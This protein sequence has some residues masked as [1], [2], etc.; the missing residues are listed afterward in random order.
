MH[1]LAGNPPAEPSLRGEV[2]VI[3]V[4]AQFTLYV[5]KPPG[6]PRHIG[7]IRAFSSV[8]ILNEE[9]ESQQIDSS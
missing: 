6:K 4:T 2:R 5:L 3:S 9:F 1:Q 7:A 8:D